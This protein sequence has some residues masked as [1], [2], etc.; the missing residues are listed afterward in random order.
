MV[1]LERRIA[2]VFS[3]DYRTS[4][5]SPDTHKTYYCCFS[6]IGFKGKISSS[7]QRSGYF[8]IDEAFQ[9]KIIKKDPCNH[10]NPDLLL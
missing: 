3:E 7:T 8:L 1:F 10:K 5:L 9:M 6:G 2:F 4:D